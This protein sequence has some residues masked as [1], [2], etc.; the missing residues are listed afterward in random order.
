MTIHVHVQT[1]T[2]GAILAI[3]KYPPVSAKKF[4]PEILTVFQRNYCYRVSL[5]TTDQ[6]PQVHRS[7]DSWML[8]GMNADLNLLKKVS[9]ATFS[10]LFGG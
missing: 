8:T 4:L 5:A 3:A 1:Y 9:S 7:F 2:F 6:K 10:K